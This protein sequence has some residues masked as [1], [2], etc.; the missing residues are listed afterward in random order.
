MDCTHA[1]QDLYTWHARDDSAEGGKALVIT[2]TSCGEVLQ[3]GYTDDMAF[4]DQAHAFAADIIDRCNKHRWPRTMHFHR[5]QIGLYI[6]LNYREED[7]SK[8][9]QMTRRVL[10]I[11]SESYVYA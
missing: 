4:E 5:K 2:C 10:E 8:Q 3:G 11:I 1:P 6:R 7:D 9:A